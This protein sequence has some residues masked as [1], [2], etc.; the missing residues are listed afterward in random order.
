MLVLHHRL[1]CLVGNHFSRNVN[2]TIQV[3][4]VCVEYDTSSQRHSG[5]SV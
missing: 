5:R 4:G 2:A 1:D 3:L